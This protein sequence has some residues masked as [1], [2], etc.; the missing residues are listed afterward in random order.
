MNTLKTLKKY[1]YLHNFDTTNPITK[2]HTLYAT[3]L[4]FVT[5]L[6]EIIRE[7]YFCA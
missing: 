3:L 7:L 1:S 5:M 6:V 2:K 4:T